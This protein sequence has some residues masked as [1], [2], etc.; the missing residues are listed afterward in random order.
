LER[1][2]DAISPYFTENPGVAPTCA[3]FVS[4]VDTMPAFSAGLSRRPA[5][6]RSIVIRTQVKKM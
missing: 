1:P 6:N 3:G 5:K 4:T 2:F